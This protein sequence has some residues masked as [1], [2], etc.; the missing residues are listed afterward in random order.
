MEKIL[1]L[2]YGSNYSSNSYANKVAQVIRKH[3][4]YSEIISSKTISKFDN[5]IKG[6]VLIGND[7]VIGEKTPKLNV[8]QL[9]ELNIPILGIEYGTQLIAWS[10]DIKI[11]K[12][13]SIGNINN[14]NINNGNINN[15]NINN[16]NI[17][18]DNI[19]N[20]NINNGIKLQSWLMSD[21]VDDPLYVGIDKCHYIW[22]EKGWQLLINGLEDTIQKLSYT[23][24]GVVSSFK[25]KGKK[26][27]GLQFHPEAK[28]QLDDQINET[29][30]WIWKNFLHMC[31]VKYTWTPENVLEKIIPEMRMKL[32]N[33]NNSKDAE[34]RIIVP[35][36]GG[37]KSTVLA[38]LVRRSIGEEN[39]LGICVDTGLLRGDEFEEMVEMYQDLSIPVDK[40]K[41][42]K[43][44][45]NAIADLELEYGSCTSIKERKDILLEK[46][47]DVWDEYLEEDKNVWLM[48]SNILDDSYGTFKINQECN[49]NMMEPLANLFRF[50]VKALGLL[51]GLTSKFVN[52]HKFP[53][54]GLGGNRIYGMITESKLQILRMVEY[55][56]INFLKEEYY[57]YQL[58]EAGCSIIAESPSDLHIFISLWARML[59]TDEV[60][61]LPTDILHKVGKQIKNILKKTFNKNNITIVYDI[62]GV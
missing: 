37:L 31:N 22:I 1:I 50:E 52:Q 47:A 30:H 2:D 20:D 42:D 7:R 35:C 57:Y 4:V 16:D 53:I 8:K 11:S 36:S 24:N 46:L 17:N 51:L 43:K 48:K 58:S 45:F 32:S 40:I 34:S 29:S 3:F 28:F 56:F 59:E 23:E 27:Y 19:N 33:S 38:L 62:M 54:I 5:N 13:I 10:Y 15:D 39:M 21:A 12:N 9:E 26:I 6:I 25:I 18:N 55:L 49:F 61:I 41:I 60:A 14:G 44:I